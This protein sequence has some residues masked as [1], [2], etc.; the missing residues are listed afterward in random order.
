MDE[1]EMSTAPQSNVHGFS[2]SL[3]R[4]D[5]LPCLL[6]RRQYSLVGKSGFCR[7]K[8]GL[9]VKAHIERLDAYE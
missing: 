7:D 3:S 2:I 1:P 6:N 9:R 8:G 5:R 4:V